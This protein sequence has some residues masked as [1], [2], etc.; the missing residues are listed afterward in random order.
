MRA[1]YNFLKYRLVYGGLLY[2]YGM[3]RH[4]RL[5]KSADRSQSH[6][7]TCFYRSPGQLEALVGPVMDFLKDREH[8]NQPLRINVFAG[9]TGAETYTIASVL[10]SHCPQ[11][12]FQ[13]FASDLHQEMVDRASHARY[14]ESEVRQGLV[15]ENFIQSTFDREEGGFLRIKSAIRDRVHFQRA[16]LLDPLLDQRLEPADIV[17]AQNVFFHLDQPLARE[18]FARVAHFLKP[19]SVFFIDGMELDMKVELTKKMGLIPLD[20][21]CREIHEMARRHIGDRWWNYYY[22]MEPYQGR[23]ADR[24][25]RF[26]TIFFQDRQIK[27]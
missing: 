24:T 23:L 22:G 26:S 14:S 12:D 7:Y 21:K 16:D 19:R 27:S 3:A 2:R 1:G 18:A 10:M 8:P 4:R 17:F 20:Y 5:L 11:L 9:S 13:I 25:R 6:T 15:S